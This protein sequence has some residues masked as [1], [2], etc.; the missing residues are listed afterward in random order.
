MNIPL[1]DQVQD[2]IGKARRGLHLTEAQ[3]VQKAGVSFEQLEGLQSGDLDADVLGKVAEVLDLD[4]RALSD[5]AHGKWHPGEIAVPPGFAAF[6]MPFEDMTV[7]A[8]LAWDHDGGRAAA[9]D[10]GGD[11]TPMLEMLASHRL[12]LEAIF[13]THTH[14]DHIADLDDFANDTGA[15]I[16]VSELEK[17]PKTTLI[18]EGRS[19]A[20]GALKITAR[21]TPGHSP[22]GMTYVVEGLN[23]MLAV[24]GDALFAGSMGGVPPEGYPAALRANRE[25]ILS[26]PDTT[27]ICPGHGP[28]TTVEAEKKHNPFYA[29]AAA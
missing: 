9:F 18:A 20:V 22:G 28:L 17:L 4:P 29:A 5:L 11:C 23:P 19:F 25:K 26:L 7:N 12:T 15:A 14:F 16:Y 13:L 10:T 8:Y 24:V 6:N 2:V 3:L 1:E 27:V 21:L